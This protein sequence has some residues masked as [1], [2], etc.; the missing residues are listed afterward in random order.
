MFSLDES[1][2]DYTHSKLLNILIWYNSTTVLP[3]LVQWHYAYLLHFYDIIWY[4]TPMLW[5]AM[6]MLCF[7]IF[8]HNRIWYAIVWYGMLFYE[9][10]IN[11]PSFTEE[12]Y[13]F[14]IFKLWFTG[15]I[16]LKITLLIILHVK[17]LCSSW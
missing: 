17:R 3:N 7:D 9:I 2:W 5:C 12:L 4:G 1:H 15:L 14:C 8:K 13:L 11:I 6:Y 16:S 10:W